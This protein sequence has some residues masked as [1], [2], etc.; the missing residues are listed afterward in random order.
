M[1]A[2]AYGILYE[3]YNPNIYPWL[4]QSWLLCK[5]TIMVLL[6]ILYITNRKLLYLSYIYFNLF[7]C[8]IHL[9]IF[10]NKYYIDNYLETIGY[11]IFLIIIPL[12]SSSPYPP[13]P[14]YLQISVFIL[15]IFFIILMIIFIIYARLNVNS[16]KN[17]TRIPKSNPRC[18][19]GVK[20][21]RHEFPR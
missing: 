15:I 7:I 17:K 6:Y 12:L 11:M 10:S 20:G 13:Y 18:C 5:Q 8:G 4:W 21:P 14:I 3:S 16:A 2:Y 19:K 9:Y 1:L